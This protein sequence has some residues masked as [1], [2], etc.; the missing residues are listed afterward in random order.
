MFCHVFHLFNYGF[1][2]YNLEHRLH[3]AEY[4]N[5]QSTSDG[6]SDCGSESSSECPEELY[7]LTKLAEVSL[8]AAAGTLNHPSNSFQ[9]RSS[10]TFCEYRRH[11]DSPYKLCE[12]TRAFFERI[13]SEREIL[14][15][16]EQKG[17]HFNDLNTRIDL[18]RLALV[19]IEILIRIK[20]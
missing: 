15:E 14:A 19:L 5:G 11:D 16:Q 13:E 12:K 9:Q 4:G 6:A 1:L 3:L 20:I 10:P 8:A 7:N 17:K 18:I 2:E